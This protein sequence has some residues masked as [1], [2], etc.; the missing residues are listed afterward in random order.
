MDIPFYRS[1][2]EICRTIKTNDNLEPPKVNTTINS[3]YIS[4]IVFTTGLIFFFHLGVKTVMNFG[5]LSLK[6]LSENFILNYYR[7][8]KKRLL[9][10]KIKK[11]FIQSCNERVFELNIGEMSVD[12]IKLKHQE[13]ILTRQSSDI[14]NIQEPNEIDENFYNIES[15]FL[16]TSNKCP[17]RWNDII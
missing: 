1:P 15:D 16:F 8:K 9:E 10:N 5:S 4:D 7:G 13:Y 6:L 14:I 17:C 11:D 2:K 12:S 3:E